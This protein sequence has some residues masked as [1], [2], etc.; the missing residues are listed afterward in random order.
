MDDSEN[1]RPVPS[2]ARFH[3]LKR[4]TLRLNHGFCEGADTIACDGFQQMVMA[5]LEKDSAAVVPFPATDY[6]ASRDPDFLSGF[7][8]QQNTSP[9][10]ACR[11]Q[12]APLLRQSALLFAVVNPDL[13]GKPGGTLETVRSALD[14]DLPIVPVQPDTGGTRPGK[15]RLL[16]MAPRKIS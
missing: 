15:E 14:F 7:D 4:P 3:A 1:D 2:I 16:G 8:K 12:S 9:G 5:V 6:R 11:C 13:E 10:G